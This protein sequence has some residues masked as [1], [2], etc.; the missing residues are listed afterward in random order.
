MG[1]MG[2][3]MTHNLLKAGYE[4]IVYNR[5]KDKCAG[6]EAAGAKVAGSAKEVVEKAKYTFAMLSD[7]EAA[8]DV[9][10]GEGGIV[11]GCSAGKGYIDVSTV[12]AATS[13]K[14]A[15]AVRSKGAAFLEAPVSG[16][17]GPA[18]QGALIFLT[19]GDEALFN[20]VKGPLDVMGKAKFF[21][22]EEGAGAKMKL[23]V[24]MV[25]GSMMTSFAEGMA[26]AD[27]AGLKQEDL[28]EVVNLGAIAAPM[29]KLKG[30]SMAQGKYDPAFPLK[31]QQKDMR[32]A[33]A[34]GDE[35]AQPLP[36]AAAANERYIAARTQDLGDMD[37]SAVMEVMKAAKKE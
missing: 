8:L 13:I 25:M 31:H 34:L 15:E 35:L 6:V 37:F 18:E 33:L 11:A 17:K 36:M 22:G 16:S 1:I 21:L 5:S 4:V 23:V 19:A 20:A 30:P 28:L 32:L 9:A 24:N 14:I 10:L 29:Y 26:L 2:V 7:P 3:P 12:D 27:K